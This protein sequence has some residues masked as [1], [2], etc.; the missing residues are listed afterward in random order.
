MAAPTAP[1]AS[2]SALFLALLLWRSEAGWNSVSASWARDPS[3]NTCV[4][5]TAHLAADQVGVFAGLHGAATV[6][7]AP[8]I[9]RWYVEPQAGA[10][11]VDNGGPHRWCRCGRSPCVFASGLGPMFLLGRFLQG[12][13]V[14]GAIPITEALVVTDDGEDIKSRMVGLLMSLGWPFGSVLVT[15]IAWIMEHHPCTLET[16]T[17]ALCTRLVI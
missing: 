11:D 17:Q 9:P 15:A 5:A 16:T 14:E 6:R 13:G 12:C 4:T 1:A 7:A 10:A 2:A 3:S 8:G